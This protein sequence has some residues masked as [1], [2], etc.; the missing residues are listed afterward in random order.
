MTPMTMTTILRFRPLVLS[1]IAQREPDDG[2]RDDDPVRPAEQRNE[3]K[4]GQ[5]QGDGADDERSDIE[6]GQGFRTP[7]ALRQEPFGSSMDAL[8]SSC[9]LGLMQRDREPG[10]FLLEAH[11]PVQG[12]GAAEPGK[13]LLCVFSPK[14]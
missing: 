2:E 12:D 13:D 8:A 5:N 4:N 6:H 14:A 9:C 11:V 1:D 3:R 10:R 7:P